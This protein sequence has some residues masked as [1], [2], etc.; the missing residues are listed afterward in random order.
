MIV[1]KCFKREWI[2]SLHT[3]Y[4]LADPSLL[5]KTIYAFELLGGLVEQ[6]IEFIFKGGTSM[7]LLVDGFRRLSIDI[8]ILCTESVE[9]YSKKFDILISNS[10]FKRWQEDPRRLNHIPK[11]HFKFYFDSVINNREDHVLL[12]VLNERNCFKTIQEK[13]IALDLFTAESNLKVKLPTIDGLVG[14]KLTAFA[15]E[16]V[17]VP[18]QENRSMQLIKQVFDLGELYPQVSD[19]SKLKTSYAS[20]LTA[21]NRYRN[22]NFSMSE[23]TADTVKAALLINQLDLRGSIENENTNI[24]RRGIR[25]IQSHLL[26]DRFSLTEAKIAAAR[27]AALAG[28]LQSNSLPAP[29]QLRFAQDKLALIRDVTLSGKLQIL[30]RIK[31]ILPEVFY[32]WYLYSTFQG[33]D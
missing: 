31:T 20:F 5:E 9:Q 8:D 6:K 12:D 23:T 27:A 25:Q 7:L 2:E 17:G 10:P 18:L 19:I 33:Q 16:T 32:Y 4:R 26:R 30:N 1:S 29:D 11:K 22:T 28:L 21:E 14:D 13:S 24:L 3:K 15:P